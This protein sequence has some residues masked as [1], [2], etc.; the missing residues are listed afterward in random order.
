[1][2]I[3]SSQRYLEYAT[4]AL[5]DH[6]SDEED[7]DDSNYDKFLDRD[8]NNYLFQ[9]KKSLNQ[10]QRINESLKAINIQQKKNKAKNQDLG[11]LELNSSTNSSV[12]YD[13]IDDLCDVAPATVD[14]KK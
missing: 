12:S 11:D 5:G 14:Q 4:I 6:E 9:R 7:Y 3:K 2:A 8:E 10:K 1:M 13:N